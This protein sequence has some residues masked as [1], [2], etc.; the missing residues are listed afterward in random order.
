MRDKFRIPA[1]IWI[2]K[3]ERQSKEQKNNGVSYSKK[4][5]ELK[6]FENST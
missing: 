2:S 6:D 5:L 4:F 3:E 1:Y